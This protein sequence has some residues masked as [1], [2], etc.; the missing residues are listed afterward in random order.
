LI[1]FNLKVSSLKGKKAGKPTE[2]VKFQRTFHWCRPC[3]PCRGVYPR[4]IG[5]AEAR[6]IMRLSNKIEK[7]RKLKNRQKTWVLTGFWLCMPLM[8]TV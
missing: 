3:R 4:K 7:R 5:R 6:E 1:L 8:Y 2:T